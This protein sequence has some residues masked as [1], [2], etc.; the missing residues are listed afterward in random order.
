L[1]QRD[2]LGKQKE[3]VFTETGEMLMSDARQL[4]ADIDG[5]LHKEIG[6]MQLK[7]TVNCLQDIQKVMLQL[8]LK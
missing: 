3:I 6:Q 2:G 7:A 4:L 8:Q 1:E 5:V